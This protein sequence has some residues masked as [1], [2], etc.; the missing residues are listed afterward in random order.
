[1]RAVSSKSSGTVSTPL[2]KQ[3]LKATFEGQVCQQNIYNCRQ[4][5]DQG[6]IIEHST[7]VR[8]QASIPN[9]DHQQNTEQIKK[10][11]RKGL[12]GYF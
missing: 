4:S 1:M 12:H 7:A 2:F 3:C 10:H 5:S 9:P 11:Q 8:L 6:R